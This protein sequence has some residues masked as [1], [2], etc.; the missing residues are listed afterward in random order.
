MAN[1][2]DRLHLFSG[3]G[4]QNRVW[5]HAK[6]G[7]PIAFIGMEFF[8]GGDQTAVTNNRAQLSNNAGVHSGLSG[9]RTI[10][11]GSIRRNEKSLPH[12]AE[13]VKPREC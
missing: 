2:Q 10:A 8:W 3:I 6:I 11:P 5:H 4:Q 1:P 9:D 7:E 12:R 13:K